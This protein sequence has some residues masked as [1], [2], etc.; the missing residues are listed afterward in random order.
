MTIQEKRKLNVGD[1]FE[2]PNG[3]QYQVVSFNSHSSETELKT[4]I[5]TR[6]LDDGSERTI[7][8]TKQPFEKII[9]INDILIPKGNPYGVSRTIF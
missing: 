8:Y 6:R 5:H 1:M 7:H 9:T 2:S 4:F 3:Y